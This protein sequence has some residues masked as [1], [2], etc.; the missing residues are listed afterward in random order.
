MEY[1]QQLFA[2]GS[3][4]GWLFVIIT[5]AAAAIAFLSTHQAGRADEKAA[6]NDKG[7]VKGKQ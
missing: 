6:V 2:G 7:Q 5:F 4:I 3:A 1:F